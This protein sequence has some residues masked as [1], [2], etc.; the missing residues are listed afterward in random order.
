MKMPTSSGGSSSTASPLHAGI[1]P[2]AA[3]VMGQAPS[4]RLASQGGTG[5]P[6]TGAGRAIGSPVSLA[7]A[8]AS[9]APEESVI[10][11]AAS[12]R[13]TSSPAEK[14]PSPAAASAL[15]PGRVDR[16]R[17]ASSLGGEPAASLPTINELHRPSSAGPQVPP[18]AE[19]RSSSGAPLEAELRTWESKL[20]PSIQSPVRGS[21]DSSGG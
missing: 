20:P 15:S 17:A 16:P 9:A 11:R 12:R 3:V 18:S 14:A 13:A 6:A 5:S 10:Q 8:S 2:R 19:P 1:Q 7:N 4:S 21:R